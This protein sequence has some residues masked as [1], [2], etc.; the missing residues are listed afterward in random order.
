[1]AKLVARLLATAA[2]WVRIQTSLKNTKKGD[3]KKPK[4]WPTHSRPPKNTQ[5]LKTKQKNN[6]SYR[7]KLSLA[8]LFSWEKSFVPRSRHPNST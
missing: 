7:K 1:L 4:E 8:L 3:I 5:K 6:F 2:L